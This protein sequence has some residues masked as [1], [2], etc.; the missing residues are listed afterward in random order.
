MVI[1]D[2]YSV[3]VPLRSNGFARIRGDDNVADDGENDDDG[4]GDKDHD[5]GDHD[6]DICC[7]NLPREI[8]YSLQNPVLPLSCDDDDG[9]GGEFEVEDGDDDGDEVE[10]GSGETRRGDPSCIP[11]H[12]DPIVCL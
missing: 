4:R 8:L 12:Q 5:D 10:E 2:D 3:N 1:Y 7:Q 9:D 11:Y 6:E